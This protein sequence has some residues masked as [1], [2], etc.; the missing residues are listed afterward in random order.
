MADV[1]VVGAGIGGLSTA[2]LLAGDGHQVT[3]LEQD[4]T[5][6]PTDPHEAWATWERRGVN[7]FRLLHIFQPR[8]RAILEAELP[9]VLRRMEDFGAVR[10]N[11]IVDAPA[12]ITGGVRD[13]DEEHEVVTG[14]RP[15]MESAFAAVAEATP[16]LTVR[17]GVAVAGLVTGAAAN[18]TPHVTGVRTEDGEELTADAVVDACGRRSR[19]PALLADIGARPPYEELEDS[20]FLYYGRHFR[21]ADG[22]VPPAFG[23]LLMPYGSVSTLTLPADNGTWGVGVITSAKDAALRPLH[24]VDCWMRTVGTFPLVAHWTDGEPLDDSIAVMAK[25]EDRYR[26]FVVDG[27]PVATGVFAVADSWACTNPS[28]GRG[29]AMGMLHAVALRDLMRN[30]FLGDPAKAALAW[31]QRTAEVVE[32]WYRA[33]LHFDRNRLAEIDAE[34][35][36]QAYEPGDPE[37]EM[38]QALSA[39]AMKDP[40]LLRGVLSIA[41]VLRLPDEV[42][43][44]PG[45]ADKV[46]ALGAGWRDERLPGP[47]RDELLSIV[48]G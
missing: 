47:T 35:A 12:E 1:I 10:F 34:V 39:G 37:W 28:V 48:A 20:G 42:F 15:V 44:A 8:A 38:T 43:S 25:I 22:S 30:G 46:V 17:R 33:T 40:E 32:P 45:F 18:G 6:P 29:M 2:M 11:P 4:P 7:Q 26:R 5:P 21:S 14:R 36:G 9:A 3:V 24:D 41:G 23:P 13:G 31:D 16:G 27:T 19:L